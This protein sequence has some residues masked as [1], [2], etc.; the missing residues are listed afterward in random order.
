MMATVPYSHN[1]AGER[2]IEDRLGHLPNKLVVPRRFKRL[3]FC[4]I[5][6]SCSSLNIASFATS[7][8]TGITVL[9]SVIPQQSYFLSV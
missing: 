5:A 1:A 7:A 6:A 8:E 9:S 4:H 3:G 2:P